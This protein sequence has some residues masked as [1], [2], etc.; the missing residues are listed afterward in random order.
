MNGTVEVA[1]LVTQVHVQR[2]EVLVPQN[3]E[4]IVEVVMLVPQE[5]VQR[6]GEQIVEVL[7]PQIAK[8]IAEEFKRV[9]QERIT[10]RLYER[11]SP[12]HM[13]LSSL[14]KCPRS[15]RGS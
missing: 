4:D 15:S 8:V 7:I 3:M 13:S 10:E 1:R 5:R 12:F 6:I 14:S 9:H 11:K 2:V